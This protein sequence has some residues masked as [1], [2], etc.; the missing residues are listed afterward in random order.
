MI[1]ALFG[2]RGCVSLDFRTL[3]P[4]APASGP[5]R[6]Y[7]SSRSVAHPAPWADLP[8]RPSVR[9][10]FPIW[11][12]TVCPTTARRQ[13]RDDDDELVYGRPMSGGVCT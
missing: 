10:S 6:M 12:A 3:R 13:V 2:T 7:S 4:A 8:V 9:L 11:A 5:V 1:Y